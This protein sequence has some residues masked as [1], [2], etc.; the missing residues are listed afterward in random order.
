MLLF[1]LIVIIVLFAMPL[2]AAL[3]V[4]IENSLRKK[5]I[6]PE[7]YPKPEDDIMILPQPKSRPSAPARKKAA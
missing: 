4:E 5:G 2:A 1:T 6:R 7:E 3:N